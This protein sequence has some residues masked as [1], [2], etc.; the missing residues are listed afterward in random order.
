[1][2]NIVNILNATELYTL[3]WLILYYV[4]FT[5]IKKVSVHV[6]QLNSTESPGINPMIIFFLDKDAKIVQ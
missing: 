3:K 4:D 5:L 6:N 1:M 2:Q